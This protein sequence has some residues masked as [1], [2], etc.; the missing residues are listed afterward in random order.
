MARWRRRHTRAD[1]EGV[2]HD[3]TGFVDEG[4]FSDRPLLRLRGSPSVMRGSPLPATPSDL[5]GRHIPLWQTTY[6]SYDA[7]DV[8][9]PC[10]DLAYDPY[11][12]FCAARHVYCAA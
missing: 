5:H 6:D 2:A 1:D 12:S 8:M 3:Q 11:D 4:V 10:A 7:Y 9:M